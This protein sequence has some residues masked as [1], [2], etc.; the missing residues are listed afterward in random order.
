VHG[1]ETPQ[2]LFTP[3]GKFFQDHFEENIKT[4]RLF[5]K[6]LPD[7]KQGAGGDYYAITQADSIKLPAPSRNSAFFRTASNENEKMCQDAWIKL[8]ARFD[9]EKKQDT[10]SKEQE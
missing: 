1:F 10:K 3:W 2:I 6:E 4:N 9:A 7:W 5:K 8:E